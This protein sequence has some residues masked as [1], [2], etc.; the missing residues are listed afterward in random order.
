M[1]KKKNREGSVMLRSFSHSKPIVKKDK[2]TW[3]STDTGAEYR[4]PY[5]TT[6][7]PTIVYGLKRD[8]AENLDRVQADECHDLTDVINAFKKAKYCKTCGADGN[9]I[10]CGDCGLQAIHALEM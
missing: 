10:R 1:L 4:R 6:K 5:W 8:E 7:T 3:M 9:N 2:A